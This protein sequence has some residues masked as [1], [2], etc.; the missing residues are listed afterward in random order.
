VDLKYGSQWSMW[1]SN[2]ANGRMGWDYGNSLGGVGRSFLVLLDLRWGTTPRLVFGM[3]Y[4]V[5]CCLKGAFPE[6]F[7]IACLRDDSCRR[8]SSV[9]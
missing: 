9:L 2:G 6:L 7:S 1:C 5:G 3:M 4:G 8:S